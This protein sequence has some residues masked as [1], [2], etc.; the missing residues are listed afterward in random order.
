MLN[1]KQLNSL[2]ASFDK[3]DSLVTEMFYKM[4][5]DKKYITY[6]FNSSKLNQEDFVKPTVWDQRFYELKV[7][8]IKA[9][10]IDEDDLIHLITSDDE[11]FTVE[12]LSTEDL[13]KLTLAFQTAFSE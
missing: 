13:Y 4:L 7:V 8:T 3:F 9:I 1:T 5:K 12:D 10:K 6:D 2:T 11:Y